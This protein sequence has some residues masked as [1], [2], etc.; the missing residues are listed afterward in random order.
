MKKI[1]H[2]A[3]GDT[4]TTIR[5][6]TEIAEDQGWSLDAPLSVIEPETED[7][8]YVRG[9]RVLPNGSIDLDL[10]HEDDCEVRRADPSEARKNLDNLLSMQVVEGRI[11]PREADRLLEAIAR[12]DDEWRAAS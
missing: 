2:A 12:L 6:L 3:S 4:A 7:T 1:V 11:D 10:I 9:A 5:V 8:L